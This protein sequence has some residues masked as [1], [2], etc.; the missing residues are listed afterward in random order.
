M[1]RSGGV[2][3]SMGREGLKVRLGLGKKDFD[4]Q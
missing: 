3:E 2:S 4:V 1:K